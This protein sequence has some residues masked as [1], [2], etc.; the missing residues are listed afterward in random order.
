[1]KIVLNGEPADCDDGL[2]IEELVKRHHLFLEA[3]LVEHNGFALQRRE[4]AERKVR[5]NDRLEILSVAA[6]G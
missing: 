5:E 3:T 6:G 4:W 1:M 2:T